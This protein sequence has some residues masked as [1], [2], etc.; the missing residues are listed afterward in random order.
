MLALR[1]FGLGSDGHRHLD[2]D[3]L[4]LGGVVLGGR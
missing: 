3:Q 2:R 4:V 1:G